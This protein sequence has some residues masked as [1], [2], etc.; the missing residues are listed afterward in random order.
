[1]PGELPAHGAIRS[2]LEQFKQFKQFQQF[3]Q[4]QHFS[5]VVCEETRLASRA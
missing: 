5:A 4:F 3:Q 1:V 2:M